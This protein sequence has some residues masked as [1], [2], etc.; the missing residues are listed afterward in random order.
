MNAPGMQIRKLLNCRRL[1]GS[2]MAGITRREDD[3]QDGPG[4]LPASILSPSRNSGRVRATADMGQKKA[5][6]GR[7]AM[8]QPLSQWCNMAGS[9]AWMRR[10]YGRARGDGATGRP[11]RAAPFGRE[12]TPQRAAIRPNPDRN[13]TDRAPFRL[14]CTRCSAPIAWH[15]RSSTRRNRTPPV[16]S[17]GP[18]RSAGLLDRA[19]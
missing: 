4:R 16:P 14:N 18:W 2:T 11:R 10:G 6:S 3:P 9:N 15:R 13:R 5:L 8:V 17:A 19:I 7:R 12:L 1:R